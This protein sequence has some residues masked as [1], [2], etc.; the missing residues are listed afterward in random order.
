MA[1]EDCQIPI[2]QIFDA[3]RKCRSGEISLELA[4]TLKAAGLL[5]GVIHIGVPPKM[6]IVFG[7]AR[8]NKWEDAE[9]YI[10]ANL[11]P[12]AS[13]RYATTFNVDFIIS[14]QLP[15]NWAHDH[16]AKSTNLF[17][18]LYEAEVSPIKCYRWGTPIESLDA[19][20]QAKLD[21]SLDD[22]TKFL[23]EKDLVTRLVYDSAKLPSLS[24]LA[25]ITTT[26][27]RDLEYI[28]N[29]LRAEYKRPIRDLFIHYGDKARLDTAVMDSLIRG[30]SGYALCEFDSINASENGFIPAMNQAYLW[31]RRML[32]HNYILQVRL[33][34]CA[35]ITESTDY[36]DELGEIND[37]MRRFTP[38]VQLPYKN[39]QSAGEE[40]QISVPIWHMSIC[41]GSGSGKSVYAYIVASKLM[42]ECKFDVVY[43]NY[44]DSDRTTTIA[45]YPRKEALEFGKILKCIAQ[46]GLTLAKPEVIEES[47]INQDADKPTAWYTECTSK[48]RVESLLNAIFS[49][50]TKRSKRS[51]RGMFVF[52]D[53][54]LNQKKNLA[55]DIASVLEFAN[56][57]R[58]S[59]MFLG[60]IHQELTN[61]WEDTSANSFIE[62]STVILGSGVLGKDEKHYERLGQ[63]AGDTPPP[64]SPVTFEEIKGFQKHQGNFAFLAHQNGESEH[65]FRHRLPEYDFL[66]DTE[67]P[68]DWRW[69]LHIEL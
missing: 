9:K 54:L 30:G 3:V 40:D 69:G 13:L 14:G 46:V 43:V 65:A 48:D 39:R 5:R 29:H 47:I 27:G 49:A 62:R 67:T 58:T 41:G 20:N 36:Y 33:I 15:D 52:F 31:R 26:G 60:L 18:D 68:K 61:F 2:Q 16:I 19:R 66:R 55:K 6:R 21:P 53:E 50:R 4:T 59:N 51:Q 22:V 57:S 32:D 38:S 45:E 24:C 56:Q 63:R 44:K 35:V 42:K 7:C 23:S 10:R 25:V 17:E 37:R 64:V 1:V 8:K 28:W 34:P 11:P 12:Q